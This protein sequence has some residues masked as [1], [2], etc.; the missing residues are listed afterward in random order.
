MLFGY[1]LIMI[2]GEEKTGYDIAK[3]IE[4]QVYTGNMDCPEWQ[5]HSSNPTGRKNIE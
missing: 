4:E 5:I 1:L 3:F 2:L